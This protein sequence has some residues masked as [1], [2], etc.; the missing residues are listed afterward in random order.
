MNNL[1]KDSNVTLKIDS[2]GQM[3]VLSKGQNTILKLI[4][5]CV[6]TNKPITWDLLVGAYYKYMHQTA[7][8]YRY[9]C[10]D[11]NKQ[12]K[13]YEFDIM[14]C[15]KNKDDRWKYKIRGRIKGWF[16]STI[17][18]LVIKNQIIIIPTLEIE[19]D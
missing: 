19:N 15:Y 13:L 8:D 4:R 2:V 10:I 11:G 1:I 5:Y 3:V 12:R 17:G 14:E 7:E 16:T 18:V 9:V 6:S